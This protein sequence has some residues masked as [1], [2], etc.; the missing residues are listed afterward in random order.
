MLRPTP[1]DR[2]LGGLPLAAAGAAACTL[3][4]LA[5]VRFGPGPRALV[6]AFVLSVLALL[7]AIDV[8]RRLLPNRIV[9]PATAAVLVAQTAF[10]PDRALEWA[11]ASV[12]AALVLFLPLLV[13]PAGMGM[14]DVKLALLLGAAL[15]KGVVAG[16]ALGALS[17]MPVALYVLLRGGSQ[18]RKAVL[19]FGPFLALGA[20][21]VLLF[22][23]V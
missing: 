4:G 1:A 7:S 14:G 5:F 15:G 13:Y 16:L 23:E 9:L 17:A 21:V 19:P 12:G 3:A 18:A 2:L 22:G 20:A 6:A 10:F 11:L 8:E